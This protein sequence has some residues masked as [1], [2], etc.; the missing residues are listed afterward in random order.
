MS[1]SLSPKTEKRIAEK[2][3]SGKYQ[4][5][6]QVVEEALALLEMRDREARAILEEWRERIAIG[7]EQAERGE[8][9]DGEEVFARLEREFGLEMDAGG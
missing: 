1:V 8:L 4:S 2:V 3:A 7:L 6:D 5:V 9:G